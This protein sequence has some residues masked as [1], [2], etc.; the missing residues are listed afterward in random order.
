MATAYQVFHDGEKW[1]EVRDTDGTYLA[2][3]D[4]RETA[5]A[6]YG[7]TLFVEA[8]AVNAAMVVMGFD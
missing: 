3:V 1:W 6:E 5:A 4:D 8:A 7:A 2:T